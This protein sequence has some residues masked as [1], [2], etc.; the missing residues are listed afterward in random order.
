[1]AL[2]HKTFDNVMVDIHRATD[3]ESTDIL[4]FL[5]EQGFEVV[6]I[7][8]MVNYGV[9]I[10]SDELTYQIVGIRDF[11]RHVDNSI[12]VF[13]HNQFI[14]NM[15]NQ[16]HI[17]KKVIELQL[18]SICGTILAINQLQ[19]ESY[20]T[21]GFV[22]TNVFKIGHKYLEIN[23]EDN[24]MTYTSVRDGEV[25]QLGDLNTLLADRMVDPQWFRH[26]AMHSTNMFVEMV[27]DHLANH[28]YY[29]QEINPK[30]NK[31]IENAIDELAAAYQAVNETNERRTFMT[32][33]HY[34]DGE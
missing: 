34:K 8:P 11:N 29:H 3:Q 25:I 33:I 19:I 10:N 9:S 5:V 30:F 23:F 22:F 21:L 26:E 18:N 13:D 4:R 7:N 20:A 15:S 31:H 32:N 24:Q 28:H 12:A 14:K 17:D 1:M 16:N 2:I 27:S 6:G